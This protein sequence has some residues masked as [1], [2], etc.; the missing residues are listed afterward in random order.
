[1]KIQVLEAFAPNFYTSYNVGDIVEIDDATAAV[2][3]ES[4]RAV[5]GQI[6]PYKNF[7][8]VTRMRVKKTRFA[9]RETR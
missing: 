9:H 6:K 7:D 1:M 2:L 3:I 8:G 5:E 4:G